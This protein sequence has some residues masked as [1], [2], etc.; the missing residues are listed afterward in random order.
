MQRSRD[1]KR[2]RGRS[3]EA[4]KQR[5][6]EVHICINMTEGDGDMQRCREAERH[7]DRGLQVER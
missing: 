1:S 7:S 5:F 4:K 3:R 2:Q 6:R